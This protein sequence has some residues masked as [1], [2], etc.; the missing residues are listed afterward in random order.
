MQKIKIVLL[1]VLLLMSASALSCRLIITEKTEKTEETGKAETEASAAT[2]PE[3]SLKINDEETSYERY[4]RSVAFYYPDADSYILYYREIPVTFTTRGDTGSTLAAA[5]R[6]ADP[7]GFSDG[8]EINS[9]GLDTENV[10]RLDVGEAFVSGMNAG[11]MY[12]SLILQCIVNTFCRYYD[13]EHLALTVDGGTYK[14][15]HLLLEEGQL[16]SA[17]YTGTERAE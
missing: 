11:A 12:E 16:L 2:E 5:Y 6:E 17:D 1:A 7:S 8:L 15:G 4:E 9:L 14:S 13:A 10:V 3:V